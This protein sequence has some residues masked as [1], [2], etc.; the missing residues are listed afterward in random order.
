MVYM[1]CSVLLQK[2]DVRLL[3]PESGMI[4][5]RLDGL[6]DLACRVVHLGCFSDGSLSMLKVLEHLTE[7]IPEFSYMVHGLC[8]FLCFFA[9]L[10][11]VVNPI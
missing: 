11:R 2:R 4:E 7:F 3:L 10:I 8:V 5:L 9:A 1:E 6:H